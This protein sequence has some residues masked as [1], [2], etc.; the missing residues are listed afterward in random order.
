MALNFSLSNKIFQR[1]TLDPPPETSHAKQI[2]TR[3][4][5]SYMVW[6]NETEVARDLGSGEAYLQ[7]PR[8]EFL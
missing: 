2:H 3:A 4:S 5:Q 1:P 8:S 7:T 6:E